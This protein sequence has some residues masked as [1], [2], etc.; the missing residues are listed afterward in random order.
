MCHERFNRMNYQSRNRIE[1]I[2]KWSSRFYNISLLTFQF[3]CVQWVHITGIIRKSMNCFKCPQDLMRS[4]IN[5]YSIPFNALFVLFLCCVRPGA[6]FVW[7]NLMWSLCVCILRN[8]VGTYATF[9]S[10]KRN[11]KVVFGRCCCWCVIFPMRISLIANL[12]NSR[13]TELPNILNAH[14]LPIANDIVFCGRLSG[15]M[16]IEHKTEF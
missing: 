12:I 15:H 4:S 1:C 3:P 9:Q 7:M 13:L 6:V 14:L 16:R 5:I 11:P 10:H 8:F 2:G